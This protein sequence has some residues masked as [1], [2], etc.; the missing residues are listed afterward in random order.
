MRIA[1][2]AW[3]NLV[4]RPL[5]P[6]LSILLLALGTAL[7]VLLLLLN[8]QL[9]EQFE[10]N[11]Q[12]IDLVIGA[13][14]SPLQLLLSSVYHVDA[15]T[16]N[17][18]VTEAA[19]YLKENHPIISRAVP[20]A[21]GD[22]YS[23]YRIVGTTSAFRELYEL[24]VG[25][26]GWWLHASEVVV[27]RQVANRLDLTPG[28]VIYSAHGVT[29]DTNLTHK[30]HPLKV[31]G[32]L[33]PSGTVAD[34]LLLTSVATVWE[35]HGDHSEHVH[36]DHEDH[37]HEHE[38]LPTTAAEEAAWIVER[39]DEELTSLLLS[40]R[41]Q[42]F[43]SL[44]MPRAVNEYTSMMAA[45]PVFEVSRLRSLLGTGT[46]ALRYLALVIMIVSGLSVFIALYGSLRERRSELALMRTMGAGPWKLFAV[47][48]SEG[49]L[50]AFAGAV[51]GL[52]LGHSAMIFLSAS[53]EGGYGY[54]FTAMRFLPGEL[55]VLAGAF[56]LGSLAALLPALQARRTEIAEALH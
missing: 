18:A 29:S 54:V 7:I 13:K 17:I 28:D 41:A 2:L 53:L 1:S 8:K 36:H 37:S 26:G 48:M 56:G 34:Q 5:G 47:L 50:L 30:D 31:V 4:H 38:H 3:K 6:L 32:I 25:T 16:G 40:F 24:E 9:E 11:L 20:L 35:T 46:D 39:Q 15:P 33:Q 42:N 44:S 27:G 51:L 43:Q 49:L 14:G 10:R 12:G 22:S 19:P 23:G 55:I 45:N 52:L 21:L